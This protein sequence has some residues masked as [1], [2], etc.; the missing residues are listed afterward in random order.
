MAPNIFYAI[1]LLILPA[2]NGG[3]WRIDMLFYYYEIVRLIVI[4]SYEL[5]CS[6][7]KGPHLFKIQ[8]LRVDCGYYHCMVVEM[9][10]VGNI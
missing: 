5:T 9:P 8:F 10:Y 4:K 6:Q 3:K 7:L 2:T 1:I